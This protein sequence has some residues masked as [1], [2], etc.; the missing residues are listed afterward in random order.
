VSDDPSP[1]PANNG[2]G[3]ATP[4]DLEAQVAAQVAATNQLP[5]VRAAAEKWAGAIGTIV[6]LFTLSGLV[7]GPD[8]FAKVNA[9][10]QPVIPVLLGL[11]VALGLIA[12]LL[13]ARAAYGWPKRSWLV[14]SL[15]MQDQRS[16]AITAARSLIVA[17]VSAVLSFALFATAVGIIWF[18]PRAAPQTSLS[19]VTT[20]TTV[21]CGELRSIDKSGITISDMVTG[22]DVTIPSGAVQLVEQVTACPV[23]SP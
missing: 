21:V 15:Y 6:G 12:T 4:A 20:S 17:I 19:L 10:W 16:A 2:G 13:A 8:D 3:E 1:I 9:A 22:H 7:K 14:G 5:N 23:V 11:A 18:A